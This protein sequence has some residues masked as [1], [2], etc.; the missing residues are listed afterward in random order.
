MTLAGLAALLENT[1]LPVT[2][3]AWP[4]NEAPALPFI[5]YLTTGTDPTFADGGVYYSFDH[6]RV[7]LYTALEDPE[8]EAKVEAALNG[9]HWKKDS[10][11]ISTERCWK[12]DYD[13]EV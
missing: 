8:L 11:Y 1:G 4:E 7:E 9:F 2:S 5:C 12:T 3:L 10:N 6:V 13:I